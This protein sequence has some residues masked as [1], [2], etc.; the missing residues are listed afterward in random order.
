METF[1]DQIWVTLMSAL[2]VFGFLVVMASAIWLV[3]IIAES[4]LHARVTKNTHPFLSD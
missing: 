4:V 2:A 1:I 3:K